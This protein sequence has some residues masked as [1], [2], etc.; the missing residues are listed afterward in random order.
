[1]NEDRKIFS[2][3]QVTQSIQ[4]TLSQ[5]Y[6]SAFW[7]KAEMNKLN[8]Y[9]HSGHCYPELVEKSE[10]KVV[11]QMRANLWKADYER[12]DQLFIKTLN[13]PLKDGIHMMFLARIQFDP[14]F[15]LSLR[16]LDIDPSFT[17]GEL[18]RE[19]RETIEKLKQ[20]QLFYA[21]KQQKMPVLPQRIAIISVE[22]SKGY[23]D[24]TKVINQNPWGYRFFHMLFPALL[25]G[26]R[27]AVTI[28]A[29]LQLI[30]KLQSHFD[31]VAIIRG[32][33]GDVG[34]S[35]YNEYI[36]AKTV[37]C[38]PLPV[39]TGIGHST[40]E[41]VTE[42]V[43]HKNAITP[44]DLADYLIQKFHNYAVPLQ[45]AEKTIRKVVENVLQPGKLA[46]Q[47]T[48]NNFF[49]AV[50]HNT[51]NQNASLIS[52]SRI[53]LNA[54]R[55]FISAD[56]AQINSHR[57]QLK[58]HSMNLIQFGIRELPVQHKLLVQASTNTLQA[59][60]RNLEHYE[61]SMGLLD[62]VNVLKR[63]YSITY[64]KGK[65][66]NSISQIH[67]ND[68]IETHLVDGVIKSKVQK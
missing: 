67:E 21:N 63:G 29:Q 4:L 14:V 68:I 6:T 7:V 2:L 37:A 53:L 30:Q 44:T 16:I 39:I 22:T 9:P 51:S 27:A 49:T 66:I 41:T 65:L 33:G 11:A 45:E 32:G 43:A 31:V 34:L 23:A 5:R 13:E 50:S 52:H 57:Q 54:V 56:T 40:N 42:M 35:C 60:T 46:F 59:Q 62:P 12:I 8:H 28:I 10:G 58:M 36:L 25:Q 15:G 18:E 1:M 26:D 48:L 64:S 24:F 55:F 20:E 19:K 38:F 17:L 61:K 3:L 47:N